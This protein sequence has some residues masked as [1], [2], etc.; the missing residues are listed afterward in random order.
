MSGLAHAQ[1]VSIE[2]PILVI[3]QNDQGQ[4]STEQ[5]ADITQMVLSA[6]KRVQTVQDS[7]SIVTVV[8]RNQ[9]QVRGYRTFSDLLDDIPG[10]EGYRP[11]FYFDTPQAF[12][13]GQARTILMLWNGVPINSPEN[14]QR[15]LGP[16]LPLG[17]VDRVEVVSGPGGVLWGANAVLGVAS[18]TTMR[19]DGMQSV[20]EVTGTIGGGDNAHGEYRA[21]AAFADDYFD[22]KLKVY[23][24][25]GL[26]TDDGPVLRPP[27]DLQVAPYP[28]PDADATIQLSPSTGA[29]QAVRDYWVPLV[30]AI[31]AGRWKVDI[32]YPIYARE[33]R[34]F[35]DFGG[36]TDH[37]FVGDAPLIPGLSSQRREVVTLGSV[38]YER[39]IGEKQN[40]SAK[41]YYTGF[42]D[43]WV[44]LVK[45]APGL[46]SPQPFLSSDRY[47]G[48]SSFLHDGAYRTG[49]TLD[50]AVAFK[51]S[52]LVFGGEAYLEGIR[53]ITRLVSGGVS[54]LSLV[55]NP[56]Q[57]VV[58]ALFANDEYEVSKRF[59]VAAG[60]RG[61]YAPGSYSPLVL[62][63]LAT[64][65]NP[66]K[67]LNVKFNVAQGFRP[68]A[69]ELTNGNDD[70]VTNPYAHR[71]SNPDL[72]PERS[73]SLEGELS[74]MMLEGVGRLRYMAWRFGYQYT[75]LDDLV[76][77]DTGGRPY[78]SNRRVINSIEARTD[79]SI[80]GGHRVVLGYTFLDAVDLQTGPQ[81]NI[82]A[83]RLTLTLEQKVA[84]HVDMY[85]GMGFIGPSEDLDRLP[86]P[87][88]GIYAQATPS[89]V[90]VDRVPPSGLVNFGV[91][92]SGLLDG[93]LDI[94]AHVQNAFNS[95]R[96]IAD[97][98]FERRTAIL[99]MA[100]PGL[101]A[102]L[103]V[104]WRM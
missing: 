82:P 22:G 18:I 62:G 44:E 11:A 41:V 1:E 73:L 101:S 7:S 59:S 12:A 65:W 95:H 43:H 45:Y 86:L 29:S 16:F 83:H 104:T 98:D 34:E 79:L 48:M 13:R 27:Y 26:I 50:D 103:S 56:G 63:S 46:L 30:F 39:R 35:N 70:A 96:Y 54:G 19:A 61:Q 14:N 20:S 91:T 15:A 72:K 40:L 71:E 74:A 3:E 51:R 94:A 67:K 58:T 21:S 55:M 93:K 102:E 60:A 80:T 25:I 69:F 97:P 5:E 6:A 52:Q 47:T 9:I 100:S 77:F 32:L 31:D 57:R 2:V 37:L 76:V 28:A 42:E 81:R 36:R 84:Q 89:S 23:G 92:A 88:S 33:Y 17:A 87:T 64:R 68:P 53:E 24:H 78:N 90:V 10:F 85:V 66:Y 49:F 38:R 99:P 4:E 75:Q 8:T